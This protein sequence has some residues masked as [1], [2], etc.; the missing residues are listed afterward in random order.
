MTSL[1]N[2]S[3]ELVVGRPD[4]RSRLAA[5]ELVDATAGEVEAALFARDL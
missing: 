2:R 5:V 4:R 1:A 3:V